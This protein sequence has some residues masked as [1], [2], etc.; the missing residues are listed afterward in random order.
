MTRNDDRT[1][2]SDSANGA[3]DRWEHERASG[4]TRFILRRGV[5]N[6]A[7]PAALLTVFYKL[8]Q[9]QGLVWSPRMTDSLRT[10]IVIAVIV[11]PVCGWIFGRWLWDTGETRYRARVRGDM[12]GTRR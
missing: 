6:W 7:I 8:V 9:E 5:L 2:G 12:D 3:V 10:A 1:A 4:R 11:F